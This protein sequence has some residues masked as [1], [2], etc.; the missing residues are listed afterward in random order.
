MR[1]IL[2]FGVFLALAP[3]WACRGEPIS[4]CQQ[5]ASRA[6]TLPAAKWSGDPTLGTAPGS[7]ALAPAL[8]QVRVLDFSPTRN[9]E[10]GL[11][12]RIARDPRVL[13]AMGDTGGP[14]TVFVQR[15]PG[16]NLY[17]AYSIQGTIHEQD[18]VFVIARPGH[19]LR[20]VSPPYDPEQDS[21][22]WTRSG[23]F[24]SVLGQSA[25]VDSGPNNQATDYEDVRITPWR[26]GRWLPA[27]VLQLRFR[28]AFRR[29]GRHCEDA[30]VC[31]AAD[32][33]GR[34]L[35][36]AYYRSQLNRRSE[37]QF[38]FGPARPDP[39]PEIEAAVQSHQKHDDTP[40]WPGFAPAAHEDEAFSQS[41]GFSYA[42]VRW[43][44]WNLAGAAR[45]S[46]VGY[47]GLAWRET[48]RILLTIYGSPPGPLTPV[49]N[50]VFDRQVVGLQSARATDAPRGLRRALRR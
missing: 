20:I 49:A 31:R 44:S 38:R 7:A 15:A 41:D 29:V 2:W 33:Q 19:R 21:D 30:H 42:G 11:A 13:D 34:R 40:D 3:A 9:Q 6:R 12:A 36:R 50:Y 32:P 18:S 14:W 1:G 35:A 16:S 10:R 26:N 17:V 39:A 46:A 8:R 24:A 5:L 27:C 48:P 47:A 43:F 23:S 4:L 25:F 22:A 37:T 28:L 45:L